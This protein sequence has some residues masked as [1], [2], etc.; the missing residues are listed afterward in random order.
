MERH[1]VIE[2]IRTM[3]KML[4]EPNIGLLLAVLGTI[5]KMG[6]IRYGET[7]G[8]NHMNSEKEAKIPSSRG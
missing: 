3:R 4:I 8:G 2:P 5:S 7:A 6:S 1:D